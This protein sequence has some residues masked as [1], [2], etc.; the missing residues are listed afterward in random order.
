[1]KNF[2]AVDEIVNFPHKTL[3]EDN[4]GEADAHI[5]Q[6]CGERLRFKGIS[7]SINGDFFY[8]YLHFTEVV[9]LHS[10]TEVQKHVGQVRTLVGQFMEHGVC[11]HLDGKLNVPQ[12]RSKTMAAKLLRF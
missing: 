8:L 6:F 2:Q 5:T 9:Q 12:R 4:L 10:R 3:H 7:D 11:D 1:V